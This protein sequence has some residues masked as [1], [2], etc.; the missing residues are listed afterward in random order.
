MFAVVLLVGGA[1]LAA[2]FVRFAIGMAMTAGAGGGSGLAGVLF[3]G[4]VGF[5]AVAAFFI[6]RR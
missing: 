3:F 1:L 5:V 2:V 6:F 4:I